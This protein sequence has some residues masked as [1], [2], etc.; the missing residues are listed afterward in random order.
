MYD[1]L[2]CKELDKAIWYLGEISISRYSCGDKIFRSR[3]FHKVMVKYFT[4]RNE[5]DIKRDYI[6][7]NNCSSGFNFLKNILQDKSN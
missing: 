4:N 3:I 6:K 5:E 1:G 2:C 7:N